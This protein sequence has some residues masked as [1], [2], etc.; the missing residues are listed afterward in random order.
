MFYT[1][2]VRKPLVLVGTMI[3]QFAGPDIVLRLAGDL[4]QCDFQLLVGPVTR[5]GVPNQEWADICLTPENSTVFIQRILPRIG[6][7]RRIYQIEIV[8][9][10]CLIFGSYDNFAPGDACAD[11]IVG[12]DLLNALVTEGALRAYQEH[13]GSPAFFG[14][15]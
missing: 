8:R 11:S 15:H 5:G 3:E 13:A 4:S 6:I 12:A 2:M 14:T 1:L 9:G 10:D 7:T